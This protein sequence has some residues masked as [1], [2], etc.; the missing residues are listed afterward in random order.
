MPDPTKVPGHRVVAPL[1]ANHLL[2]T[3]RRA[4]ARRRRKYCER[5]FQRHEGSLHY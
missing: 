3:A 4:H 2:A 1:S 5:L